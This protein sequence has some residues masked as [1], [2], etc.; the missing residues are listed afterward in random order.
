MMRVIF[1]LNL[2]LLQCAGTPT[3]SWNVTAVAFLKNGGR[4]TIL[5]GVQGEGRK[6]KLHAI[7][8]PSGSGKTTLLNTLANAVPKKSL[9]L[10][11]DLLVDS[12]TQSIFVQQEDLLF[13]QL[14]VDE[15]LDTSATLRLKG[16]DAD[17]RK[18][19]T[20]DKMIME[21]SLKKARDTKVGDSKTRGISGGEKKRLCIGNECIG[22]R[23]LGGGSG[24]ASGM[25]TMIFADE[26][27]SGECSVFSCQVIGIVLTPPCVILFRAVPNLL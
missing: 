15:T 21:L 4:K 20:V 26:P 11:G 27:T 13:A 18:R 17:K 2:W 5:E 14:T 6:S 16:N 19:A 24:S 22:T 10:T 7:V 23:L 9:E 8:G 25:N 12:N 3:V 1:F